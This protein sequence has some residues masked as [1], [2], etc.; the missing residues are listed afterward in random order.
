[1]DVARNG[2]F[3]HKIKGADLSKGLRRSKRNPRNTGFSIVCNGAVGKD[4]I[5]Q[6]IEEVTRMATSTITDTFPFPQLFVFTN[7]IIVC[8]LKK[9]YEWTGSLSLKHTASPG[10]LWSA[11]DFYDYIYLSNGVEAVVRSAS[12]GAYSISSS[13]YKASAMCNYNGQVIL[14]APDTVGEGASLNMVAD[15]G[16]IELTAHGDFS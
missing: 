9:V 8:G 4:G 6:T 14:G 7:L 11:V 10:G 12:T 5:L 15:V 13:L 2:R 1:M 16:E 3:S